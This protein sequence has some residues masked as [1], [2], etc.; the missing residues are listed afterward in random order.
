MPGVRIDRFLASTAIIL[1][2]AGTAG[3]A[4]AEPKF[5]MTSETAAPA[6]TSVPS[7]QITPSTKPAETPNQVPAAKPEAKVGQ[8]VVAIVKPED[9]NS[10]ASE[11]RGETTEER[12]ADPAAAPA[13]TPAEQPAATA[14]PSQPI[15]ATPAPATAT[16]PAEPATEGVPATTTEAPAAQPATVGGSDEVPAVGTTTPADTAATP[17]DKAAPPAENAAA[18]SATPAPAEDAAAPANP[19]TPPAENATAPTATPAENAAAPA[20]APV[21]ADANTPIATALRELANGKFDRI[22]GKKDRPAFDAYYAAHGYAPVWISDGQFNERAKAAIAYLGQ[23]DADGLDPADYPVPTISSATTDPAALA[24]AEIRLSTS[25]ATYAHHAATGRVHWS[26]VSN[27]ILFE[28]KAPTPAEVLAAVVDSKDVA[29]TLAGYEPQ[30]P[31]YVAL[32]AKLADLRGGKVEPGKAPIP[33][34]AGPKLGGQDN[35][36]PQLRE[37]LGLSG[38]GT[39]YD[40]ELADAVKKFQQEHE[41]RPTGLLTQQTI[42]AINGRAADRPATDVVLANLERW[43]WMPH[44]LGKD[45]VMVN[46]P[47]FTLRVFHDGHQIWITRIVTGK[48]GMPT[49]IMTAEMKF[50]TVNPT[51]NVPPSIVHRE[52]LPALAADPTVLSRMGLRMSYNSDGSVHISQPPGDHNALGRLRFNFPNKFLVYQHDTPDKNLFALDKRAFSHGCMR[53]QD[54]V[55]YAEVLLSITRP[56]EGYTTDRIRK[57]ISSMGEQDIQFPHYL[58]VHLTYQTAFVDD[59]GKL[60]FRE[61]MY[62]RDRAL[63]AILKSDERRVAESAV[64]RPTGSANPARREALAMPVDRYTSGYSRAGGDNFFSRLF[65]GGDAPQAGPQ[66]R[67]AAQQGRQSW[68]FFQ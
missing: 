48:P 8:P 49:P 51:W 62:G 37:R 54:P 44:D 30:A 34:G 17:A 46:L 15:E 14:A 18:P 24:E 5:G 68:G 60:E 47:D 29:A 42:D 36:L 28:T 57:M 35:R 58:P 7:G 55:K 65:G 52:Y 13:E 21:V 16:A 45:Y 39:T 56:G 67:R 22:V 27:D 53:V 43:R 11:L 26:R 25:V 6:A 63:I 33:N 10:T 40:K 23:V 64:D 41:I 20:A 2:V 66:R 59:E 4:S 61:D 9:L 1:L 19:A 50:I 32:K 38:D 12:P 3:V 31:N